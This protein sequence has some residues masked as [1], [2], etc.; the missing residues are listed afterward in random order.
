M[1]SISKT[2]TAVQTKKFDAVMNA[3]YI[4]RLEKFM[5]LVELSF[6]LKNAPRISKEK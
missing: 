4:E 6:A 5:A 1:K 2:K 3:I